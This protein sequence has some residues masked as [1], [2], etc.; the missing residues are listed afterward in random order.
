M[1]INWLP[2]IAAYLNSNVDL[3]SLVIMLKQHL[4]LCGGQLRNPP[5]PPGEVSG[6]KNVNWARL[7]TA[8]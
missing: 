7:V 4:I 1:A 8:H 6:S 3:T 2:D 5:P